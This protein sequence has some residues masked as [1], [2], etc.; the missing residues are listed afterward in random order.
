MSELSFKTGFFLW[1]L[2]SITCKAQ[3]FQATSETKTYDIR[4]NGTAIEQ[5]RTDYALLIAN[6]SYSD[7]G[8]AKLNNP[9]LDVSAIEKRLKDQFGF[10]TEVLVDVDKEACIRK[11]REYAAKPYGKY[12]QLLIYFAGH[13]DFDALLRQGYVVLN[14]SKNQDETYAKHLSFP[15]LQNIVSN[16]RCNHILLTLDV[17]YGG[18]FD[19][20]FA[21]ADDQIFRG[22]NLV[23]EKNQMSESLAAYT[24]EKLKPITR[25]YLSAGGKET[26]SDG[27]KGEHS[28][29]AKAFIEKLDEAAGSSYKILT[30]GGL[31]DYLEKQTRKVKM[32]GFGSNQSNSDFLFVAN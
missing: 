9:K 7:A 17:C 23:G 20:Y 19:S 6:E 1:V 2:F 8:Y 26:V 12:D 16:L 14:D 32:N 30:A 31:K 24:M 15:E 21:T 28:P 18:T 5:T 3:S 11:L 22:T 25:L 4:R 13:G 10:K 27:K 29:F